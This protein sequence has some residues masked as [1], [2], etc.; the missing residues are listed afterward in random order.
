M[1]ITKIYRGWLQ[2]F[3]ID[4][5]TASWVCNLCRLLRIKSDAGRAARPNISSPPEYGRQTSQ[6]TALVM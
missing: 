1:A 4:D 2:N 3:R 5:K 6:N